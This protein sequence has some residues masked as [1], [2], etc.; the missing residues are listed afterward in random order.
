MS[1]FPSDLFAGRRYAVVGLG[2]NGMPALR[3]LAAARPG[4]ELT[5]IGLAWA[6]ELA[7]RLPYVDRFIAFPGAP[8]LPEGDADAAAT[9][10]FVES[11]QRERFDLLVQMHGSGSI[12]NALLA[13]CA[14]QSLAGFHPPGEPPPATGSFCAWPG[15]GHE[16][17]RL[18]ALTDRLGCPRR[19]TRLDFPLAESDRQ[20]LAGLPGAPP[21]G[22]PYVCVHPGARLGSRRWPPERFAAVGDALAAAGFAV[23]VTGSAAEVM[24]AGRVACAMRQPAT[25]LAGRTDLWTLGA[26]LERAWLV[27]TND[28][29]VSH[30]AAALEVPSLVVAC[31]SEVPRWAPLDRRRHRVLWAPLPCRPCMHDEGCPHEHACAAAVTVDEV[32]AAA[33]R[34]PHTP[35]PA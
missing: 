19:G 22:T 34:Q 3:A 31:G 5:L 6:G 10:G 1:G 14:T 33:R 16:V 29:G 20:A 12:V 13:R 28:T 30:L 35:E 8:G 4:A 7:A 27:V 23:V 2:R 25:V 9:E 24:L 11:M 18:F 17:E 15:E 21:R 26:L 32:V